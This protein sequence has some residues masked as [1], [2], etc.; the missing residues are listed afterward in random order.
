MVGAG[1]YDY[2]YVPTEDYRALYT[3]DSRLSACADDDA[4]KAILLEE[5]P[6]LFGMIMGNNR[7][8]TTQTFRQLSTAFFLGLNP[9]KIDRLVGRLSQ[10]RY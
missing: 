8:F 10:L 5:A 2:Q 3:L 1:T 9:E 4:A 7:E 6:A